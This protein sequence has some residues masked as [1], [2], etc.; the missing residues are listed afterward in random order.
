MTLQ[1]KIDK[2]IERV[3]ELEKAISDAHSS[4]DMNTQLQML[5][6]A[7]EHDAARLK[8]LLEKSEVFEDALTAFE[9]I[10]DIS[11]K[12]KE[13]LVKALLKRIF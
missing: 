13:Q 3:D 9:N 12:P 10:E 4:I 8:S 5:I 11:D 1:E 6:F 2:V 7:E